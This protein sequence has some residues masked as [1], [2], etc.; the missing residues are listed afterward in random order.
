MEFSLSLEEVKGSI[1]TY[2]EEGDYQGNITQISSLAKAEKNHLSFL[3]NSKYR[4]DVATSK[5][6]VILLEKNYDLSSPLKNQI[7][8]RVENTSLSLAKL[9]SLIEGILS[10]RPEPSI[11]DKALIHN[12]VKLGKN[13]HIAD[14]VIIEANS[15]IGDDTV[16][17]NNTFIAKNVKIGE[18][19]SIDSGV[20]VLH[21]CEIGNHVNISAGTVVGSDGFGYESV[22]GCHQKISHIGNVVIEDHVEIGANTT[23]DRARFAS[24]TVGEG[25][26]IDNL[27]Q[28]GH[29]VEIGKHCLIVAQVG[30]SGSTLI[31]DHTVIG[32]QAGLAGH[33]KIGKSSMIAAQSGVTKDIPT[34][35]FVRGSPAMPLNQAH[36]LMAL[37]RKLPNIYQRLIE[38]E[39]K[40]TENE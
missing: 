25:T 24:T 2:S 37:Q 23:I 19:C 28:I 27:V 1:G 17:L 8:L 7:Y 32:G 26:K 40:V 3:S 13:V 16:I 22:R 39:T 29:N 15:V 30:I 36:K 31:D 35:S 20:Q 10:P 6:S 21:H 4:S 14:F 33:L 38:V 5:A 18:N 11:S 9:C 12:S 34:K